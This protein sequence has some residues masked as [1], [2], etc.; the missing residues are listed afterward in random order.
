M[1]LIRQVSK[2]C[3]PIKQLL[4][5]CQ[6]LRHR[7]VIGQPS[8]HSQSL[9]FQLIETNIVLFKSFG[10]TLE[11]AFLIIGIVVKCGVNILDITL[12][13]LY[14]VFLCPFTLVNI[15]AFSAA[16]IGIIGLILDDELT[17][18]GTICNYTVSLLEH[19]NINAE[20]GEKRIIGN[21][22]SLPSPVKVRVIDMYRKIGR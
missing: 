14:A 9:F 6:Y 7:T 3:F 15:S 4:G 16:K 11:L 1:K 17:A 19:I 12:G 18:D 22:S 13:V 20:N 10:T 5:I 21:I 2:L 8:F